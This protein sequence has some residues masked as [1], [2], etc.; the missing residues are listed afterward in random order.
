MPT[1]NGITQSMLLNPTVILGTLSLTLLLNIAS[2]LLPT[3]I[4]LKKDIV[5]SLYQRR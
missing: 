4:A 5:Q 3:M 1:T 2:A